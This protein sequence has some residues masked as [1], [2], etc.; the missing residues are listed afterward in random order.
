MYT[1]QIPQEV[2][3][4][5][6][7]NGSMGIRRRSGLLMLSSFLFVIVGFILIA[8]FTPSDFRLDTIRANTSRVAASQELAPYRTVV[9]LA[10][11]FAFF[12]FATTSLGF[13]MLGPILSKSKGRRSFKLGSLFL[14]L[15]LVGWF[16]VT[17]LRVAF[18][19]AK[20]LSTSDIP[21]LVGLIGLDLTAQR[22][23]IILFST[24]V[25]FMSWSL[26]KSSLMR[27]LGLISAVLSFLTAAGAFALLLL[28]KGFPP[29]TVLLCT[30]AIGI[31]LTFKK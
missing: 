4:D 31:G 7:N 19:L 3:A 2:T 18:D 9:T 17:Y 30:Y 22:V 26:Y 28:G 15:S 11:L 16:L 20:I 6:N 25:G 13:W 29:I 5:S 14:L 24:A 12:T 1:T 10:D 27:R 23:T 21:P 8:M